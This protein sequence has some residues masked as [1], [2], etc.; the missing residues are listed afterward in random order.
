MALLFWAW[1]CRGGDGGSSVALWQRGVIL[2]WWRGGILAGRGGILLRWGVGCGG[3]SIHALIDDAGVL[4]VG[5]MAKTVG[6]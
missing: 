2:L 6:T 1:A 3:S 5:G 4:K